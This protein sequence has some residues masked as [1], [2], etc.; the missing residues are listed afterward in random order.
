MSSSKHRSGRWQI[1][2]F[3]QFIRECTLA[4]NA[5]MPL[6]YIWT[7]FPK[8][9][10][11]VWQ[12]G[13]LTGIP[14]LCGFIP[15]PAPFVTSAH[16]LCWV[17]P[18]YPLTKFLHFPCSPFLLPSPKGLGGFSHFSFCWD[19]SWC[20]CGYRLPSWWTIHARH[21][22]HLPTFSHSRI[23]IRCLPCAMFWP[24]ILCKKG[25]FSFCFLFVSLH[26]LATV[27][28]FTAMREYKRYLMYLLSSHIHSS[29]L[30]LLNIAHSVFLPSYNWEPTLTL[31]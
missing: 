29:P 26:F 18:V 24:K 19:S 16:P 14:R 4:P 17:P 25:C 7:D 20:V 2:H 11:S 10:G 9:L 3:T 5:R 23:F 30:I 15:C 28:R 21:Y 22:I 8:V 13:D 12:R 6:F 27:I 31:L 1:F